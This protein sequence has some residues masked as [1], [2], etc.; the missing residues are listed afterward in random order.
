M[1]VLSKP[2]LSSH[3]SGGNAAG[4]G[5]LDLADKFDA[6]LIDLHGVIWSGAGLY[7]GA[8][9]RVEALRALGKKVI[10]V[11]NSPKPVAF[12]EKN[13]G[14]LGVK[15]GIHYDEIITS[16]EVARSVLYSSRLAFAKNSSPKKYFMLYGEGSIFD[17]SP[18]ER[19]EKLEDADFVFLTCR[20]P[21]AP[22]G[23]DYVERKGGGGFYAMEREAWGEILGRY[24]RL[25][26]PLLNANPDFFAFN[27]AGDGS[28]KK[29]VVEGAIANL[30]ESMGGEVVEFGKP[31]AEIFELAISRLGG[32]DRTRTAMVGDTIRT[33]IKG[34]N[35]AGIKSILCTGTGVTADAL[36]GGARLDELCEKGGG[37]PDFLIDRV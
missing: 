36:A 29:I 33:D 28:L 34:A 6:F 1:K 22:E 12:V 8:A 24:L 23:F 15:K 7:D 30:Y 35:L 14:K 2:S 16:G 13:A 10:F 25:D 26:M 21:Y 11:S 9:E 32:I 20:M 18:Y 3:V 37:K 19:A 31:R 4:G 17:G 27:D 5:I